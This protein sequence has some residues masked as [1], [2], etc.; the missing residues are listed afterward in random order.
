MQILL[1]KPGFK[2]MEKTLGYSIGFCV[3]PFPGSSDPKSGK[4]PGLFQCFPVFDWQ[5]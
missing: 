3:S 2:S 5:Y 1:N 4:K